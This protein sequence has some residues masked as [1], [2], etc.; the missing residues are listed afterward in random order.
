MV[1]AEDTCVQDYESDH[2]RGATVTLI[3]LGPWFDT[4]RVVCTDSF[5]GFVHATETLY[6]EGLSY[7]NIRKE[8]SEEALIRYADG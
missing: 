1:L 2:L 5:F 8:I 4:N 3:L 6:K 7:E